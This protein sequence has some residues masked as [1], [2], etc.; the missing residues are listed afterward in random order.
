MLGRWPY[1]VS[2]AVLERVAMAIAVGM[3][4]SRPGASQEL[5]WGF[6]DDEERARYRRAAEAA[7]IEY[8]A[9]VADV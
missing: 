1:D 6:L 7:I 8:L 4:A 2:A 9:A 3:L 5:V